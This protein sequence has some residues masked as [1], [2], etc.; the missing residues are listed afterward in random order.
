MQFTKEAI[1]LA[2]DSVEAIKFLVEKAGRECPICD[3]YGMIDGDT[4]GGDLGC[5]TCNGTGKVGGEWE[6]EPKV[7]DFYY[8]DSGNRRLL[9]LVRDENEAEDIAQ[10][11]LV[12]RFVLIP[13]LRWEDDIEPILKRMK[14]RLE[15]THSVG[16]KQACSI[17]LL[18]QHEVTAWGKDRQT[19]VVLAL[20]ELR[21]KAE[22]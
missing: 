6:W 14:Y 15:I 2:K 17:Y 13:L 11:N 3:G 20:I 16:G 18:N 8:Q 22:K 1:A 21:K 12:K 7:G 19:S 4:P 10:R 5:S 9:S